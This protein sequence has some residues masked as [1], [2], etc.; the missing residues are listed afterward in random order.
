MSETKRKRK[1]DRKVS[2]QDNQKPWKDV[3]HNKKVKIE[4]NRMQLD[5]RDSSLTQAKGS[6]Y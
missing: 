1:T 5:G 4:L 6:P 3:I 2:S